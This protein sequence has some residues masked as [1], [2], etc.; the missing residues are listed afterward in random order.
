MA[1]QKAASAPSH[2][3]SGFFHLYVYVSVSVCMHTYKNVD[4]YVKGIYVCIIKKQ[5]EIFSV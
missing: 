4:I 5:N 1:V 3:F 2:R